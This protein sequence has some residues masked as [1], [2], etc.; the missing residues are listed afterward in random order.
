MNRH[1][2]FI[3][4]LITSYLS[5]IQASVTSTSDN[6]NSTYGRS[7]KFKRQ[8]QTTILVSTCGF[9]DGDANQPRT[10]NAG[11][12]CRVD[13]QHALW[14]FCPTTAISASDCGLAGN[15]VDPHSCSNG[16]GITG[17]PGITTF[18]WYVYL[19]GEP[20]RRLFY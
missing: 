13:T 3:F 6:K 1:S 8:Q 15:C 4:L 11:Y 17:T 18:T 19:Q 10:A 14:G 7:A 5:R 2:F 9:K 16:C 20:Q 12:D